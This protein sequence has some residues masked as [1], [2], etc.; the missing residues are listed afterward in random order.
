[1]SAASVAPVS[2]G[3]VDGQPS[4][5]LR[6]FAWVSFI[7]NVVIIGTGGAVRLTGSGLGCSEWPLCTPESLVPTA[8]LGIHGLIEFGN[9]TMTGVLVLAALAVLFTLLG[10]VGGRPAVMNATGYAI[11]AVVAGAIF[12]AAAALVGLPGFSFFNAI[13]LTVVGIA[14]VRSLHITNARRD[15][16]L[17]AWIALIGVVMQ[18]FVGGIT[19]LTKLNPAIVGFHYVSSLLLACI[20]A[21]FIVRMNAPSTARELQVPKPYAI[22]TH[23]TTFAMAV[24]IFVGVLTTAAGPHSG[25]ANIERNGFDASLLAHLHSWP[26][27]VTFAL[28]LALVIWAAVKR[29]PPLK[30][31]VVLL[32][33]LIVQ[34]LV[35]I[36]QARNGLPPF[37][38]GVHMVLATLAASAMTVMVLKLKRLRAVAIA[39]TE[40]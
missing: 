4:R 15:L 11:Y 13:L 36:Y 9:R 32:V 5:W 19:V 30:W 8:E 34:I 1:L 18:A 6:I 24:L 29:L 23:I 22:L 21:A 31:A 2:T 14:A 25:D 16:V 37:F 28:V 3:I 7:A 40:R 27:Y 10:A 39:E 17:L 33:L 12:F 38:V 35:G 26:G 20:T